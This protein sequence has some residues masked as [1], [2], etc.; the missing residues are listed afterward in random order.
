MADRWLLALLLFRCKDDDGL[1]D[2]A[3]GK[4]DG[5][6]AKKSSFTGNAAAEESLP[7]P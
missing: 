6:A 4:A 2:V 1:V 7:P 5:A 3:A